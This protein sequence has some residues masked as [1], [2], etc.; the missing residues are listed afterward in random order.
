MLVAVSPDAENNPWRLSAWRQVLDYTAEAPLFGHPF[1]SYFGSQGWL[2]NG[3]GQAMDKLGP[4]NDYI[5]IVSKIGAVGLCALV[6]VIVVCGRRL[7]GSIGRIGLNSLRAYRAACLCCLIE[8]AV[9]VAFN[10]ELRYG[11][12]LFIWLFMGLAGVLAAIQSRQNRSIRLLKRANAIEL[13]Q[14]PILL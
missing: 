8:T 1:G 12:F 11:A 5:S 9:Y 4:H 3:S 7:F 13:G 6:Y 2:V 14:V 10:T